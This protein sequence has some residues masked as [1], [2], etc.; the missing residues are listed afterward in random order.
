MGLYQNIVNPRFWIP[1]TPYLKEAG[2]IT[3]ES[4]TIQGI[5]RILDIEPFDPVFLDRDVNHQITFN[6]LD[7]SW[8]D[9]APNL[10]KFFIGM[11]AQKFSTSLDSG[12]IT[13]DGVDN[14]Q[15]AYQ[16]SGFLQYNHAGDT[17]SI[18]P[19][20]DGIYLR[21]FW[22]SAVDSISFN[23]TTTRHTSLGSLFIGRVYDSSEMPQTPNMGVTFTR[24]YNNKKITTDRGLQYSNSHY[25]STPM[26]RHYN[27]YEKNFEYIN[28]EY[29]YVSNIHA[30]HPQNQ[31]QGRSDLRSW[32]LSYSNVN[33]Q[34]LFSNSD[35]LSPID[36]DSTEIKTYNFYKDNSVFNQLIHFTQGDALPFLFQSD[37][38]NFMPD[39]FAM[40]RFG[41]PSFK[42]D[43]D[44]L[45]TYKYSISILEEF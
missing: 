25:M 37:E 22:L 11:I 24:S 38:D 15:F 33:E 5:D 27:L 1:I 28:P 12:Y 29:P 3:V 35:S 44:S 36:T 14:S 2:S 32:D 13:L 20:Y 19:V 30:T 45:N 21:E 31:I 4:S 9:E 16:S 26:S 6:F 17:S 34:K 39:Q 41:S 23:F 43:R 18:K 10:H 7:T 42:M 8:M 40:C